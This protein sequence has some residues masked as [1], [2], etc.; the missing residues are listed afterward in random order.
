MLKTVGEYYAHFCFGVFTLLAGIYVFFH[1]GYLDDP[2]VTPP[3]PPIGFEHEALQFADDWWFAGLL[4]VS[5][6]VLLVGV[7]WDSRTCR[8]VGLIMIA[9]LYGALSVAFMWR[10]LFDFRFNL[11]WVFAG[12]ALALLIGTAMRG[13]YYHTH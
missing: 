7:F 12:L 5:G 13:D 11:T 10:G 3:P 1:L 6:V 2:R 9:P 8:N 4:V